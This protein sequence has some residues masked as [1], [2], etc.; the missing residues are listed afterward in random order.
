EILALFAPRPRAP[1]RSSR[2]VIRP[3]GSHGSAWFWPPRIERIQESRQGRGQRDKRMVVRL[4][5]HRHSCG[6]RRVRSGDLMSQLALPA[7]FLGD[8][9][10]S[11]G[12]AGC[13]SSDEGP[14]S[15]KVPELE[16]GDLSITFDEEVDALELSRGATTLLR[17]P[18]DAFQW[19]TVA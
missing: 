18:K 13:G 17:L 15:P 6:F 5:E 9:G 4:R 2:C 16:S 14:E 8:F 10:L 7:R 3:S 11:L 19:G 12:L 1:L